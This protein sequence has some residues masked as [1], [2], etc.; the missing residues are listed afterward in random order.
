[1]A[2]LAEIIDNIKRKVGD[3]LR[4]WDVQHWSI[5]AQRQAIELSGRTVSTKSQS[6]VWREARLERNLM[7]DEEMDAIAEAAQQRR[8]NVE[9]A[10]RMLAR[11]GYERAMILFHG[12]QLAQQRT[13]EDVL[14]LVERIRR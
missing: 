13:R 11:N 12:S 3:E 10:E 8:Q 7:T 9:A 5:A 6:E 4:A 2:D 14:R 1:M